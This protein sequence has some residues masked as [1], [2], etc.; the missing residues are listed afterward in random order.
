M[1][2]RRIRRAKVLARLLRAL[3]GRR[4]PEAQNEEQAGSGK[5]P[6][7]RVFRHKLT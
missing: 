6:R 4:Y 5:I 1:L 2:L 7:N 3:E